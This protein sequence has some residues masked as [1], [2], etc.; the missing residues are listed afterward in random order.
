[1]LGTVGRPALTPGWTKRSIAV[2][3]ADT[4]T[5]CWVQ[6]LEQKLREEQD[7]GAKAENSTNLCPLTKCVTLGREL[8][9]C[10]FILSFAKW[11]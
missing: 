4:G 7:K 6:I 1:M 5:R 2:K 3:S 9:L 10:D 11:E 8:A